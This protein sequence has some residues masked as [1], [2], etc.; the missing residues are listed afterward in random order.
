MMESFVR[1]PL[2]VAGYFGKAIAALFLIA[3]L[4]FQAPAWALA[5]IL[6]GGLTLFLQLYDR[7]ETQAE[8]RHRKEVEAAGIEPASEA[9]ARRSLQV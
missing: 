4:V 5:L 3:V 2:R 8:E 7:A 9:V 1:D 6:I